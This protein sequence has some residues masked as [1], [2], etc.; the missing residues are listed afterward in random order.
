MSASGGPARLEGAPESRTTP[1][2][3]LDVEAAFPALAAHRRTA[4]RMHPRPGTPTVR[5]SSV[6]GPVL[7]PGAKAPSKHMPAAS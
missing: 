6:A 3:P 5:D 4:T 2:R 7:W 1:P